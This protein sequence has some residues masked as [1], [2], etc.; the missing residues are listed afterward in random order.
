[1][2]DAGPDLAY[3]NARL[4]TTLILLPN[5]LWHSVARRTINR[6]LFCLL[7]EVRS[8][9]T[10]VSDM[11]LRLMLLPSV[12]LFSLFTS[13]C[14]QI[15]YTD[16]EIAFARLSSDAPQATELEQT[17]DARSPRVAKAEALEGDAPSADVAANDRAN[18]SDEEGAART[19]STLLKSDAGSSRPAGVQEKRPSKPS[20]S[21]QPKRLS[22]PKPV[23]PTATE[24]PLPTA[25]TAPTDAPAPTADPMADTGPPTRVEIPA[26]GVDATVEQVGLTPDRAMDVPKGWMNVGWYENGFYPGE[27]GNS[28]IAG[29]LDT[30]TGGPAVFWDLNQL[31]PGDE[32]TVTYENGSRLTFV[33]VDNRVYNYDAQGAI[34]ESIFGKSLTPDLNLVTCDGAWDQGLATYAKRLVVFTTLVPEK[35]VFAGGDSEFVD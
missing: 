17:N 31:I 2:V 35:S 25:T 9:S 5:R 32:I 13:G 12:L 22:R 33:M 3:I 19:D 29:H 24:R 21:S 26:I 34:I 8:T 18:K 23:A 16:E 28:V 14:G 1:L 7:S 30:S 20:R 15:P 6:R 11:N 10:W 27:P 4:T